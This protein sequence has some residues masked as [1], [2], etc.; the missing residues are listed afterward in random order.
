MP[1]ANC[2]PPLCARCWAVK[3]VG[4]K[5]LLR[6]TPR[7]HLRAVAP[8]LDTTSQRTRLGGTITYVERQ[9]SARQPQA[10]GRAPGACMT[11]STAANGFKGPSSRCWEYHTPHSRCACEAWGVD[12]AAIHAEGALAAPLASGVSVSSVASKSWQARTSNRFP[13]QSRPPTQQA[14]PGRHPIC[15]QSSQPLAR[16][17]RRGVAALLVSNSPGA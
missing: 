16:Q 3:I 15:L 14:K 4:S 2:W 9:K 11:Q 13:D 12:K 1:A 10:H 8:H 17:S 7:Q 6:C 5:R